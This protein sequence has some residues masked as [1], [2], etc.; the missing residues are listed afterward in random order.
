MKKLSLIVII[1]FLCFLFVTCYDTSN[2]S[3]YQTKK[4]EKVEVTKINLSEDL[5]IDGYVNKIK[6]NKNSVS[7]SVTNNGHRNYDFY[8]NANYFTIDNTPVGEVIIDGKK[9]QQNNKNGGFFTSDGITP[10]FYFGK[11]PNNV[12]YSSETHTPIIINGNPNRKIF[13]KK[14]AKS[15]FPRLVIGENRNKDIIVLHT[16]GDTRCS[17]EEFYI[18]SQKQGLVNALMFDGG[19]SIE[20][21]VTYKNVKYNYQIV[22]DIERILG[23]VPTPSVF[24]VG[25]F[26]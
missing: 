11:R 25:N 1:P 19:A 8:I 12:L 3:F 6:L 23:K 13:N 15:K 22:S 9:L 14:W 18:I 4:N 21:G 20:V 2:F 24:I 26:D 7:Y 17:V 10:S 16:I 5:G